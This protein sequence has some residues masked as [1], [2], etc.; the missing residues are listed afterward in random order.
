MNQIQKSTYDA[1]LKGVGLGEPVGNSI[2]IDNTRAPA[3]CSAFAVDD[4][5]AGSCAAL[6]HLAN[7]YGQ[8]IGHPEQ[9]AF[10]DRRHAGNSLNS[11]AWHFQNDWQLD[12]RVVHTDIN[13]FFETKDSRRIIYNGAYPHLR[14]IV[15]DY[16][17]VPN[18]HNRIAKATKQYNALD[19]EHEL[20]QLGACVA[21][22]RSKAEWLEHDQ[23][24]LLS[25]LPVIT[26][27]KIH[28]SEVISI[29]KASR[30][31]EGIKVLDLS[32]VVAG[33]TV[34]RML[35]DHGASVIHL[36][37]PYQDLIYPFDI[38]TSYGKVNSYMDFT[39]AG[40][41]E[42]FEELISEC[43]VFSTGYRFG[44][45]KHLGFDIERVLKLNPNLIH[46]HMNAYGFSG[47]WAEK[48]GFEQ[49]AQSVTGAAAF[50]G[51]GIDSPQLVPAY[52]NDYLTGYLG[53]IGVLAALYKQL[54][55][56]GAWQVDVSLART[57]MFVMEQGH[58]SYDE[59]KDSS[60]GEM[61]DWLV[62]Q[63]GP[64]GTLTRLKPVIDYSHMPCYSSITGT[65]PGTHMAVWNGVADP[66]YPPHYPT[67]R[68][69]HL[70]LIGDMTL[71]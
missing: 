57:C 53:T 21:M 25:A 70:K 19:L 1:I 71:R 59:Q 46:V 35:A 26:L 24:K 38:E 31:L 58:V 39:R 54:S 45:L 63:V 12:I 33:P 13:G 48:R 42:R 65:A 17:G 40:C 49:L 44:G 36:R 8:A 34:A 11:V 43:N 41:N 62:D 27:N 67:K 61:R 64:L 7:I 66:G 29:K 37:H 9:T 28:D 60:L 50:Q 52:M 14:K 6:A 2:S 68:F 23:G 15:L 20:S 4:V 22:V 56:G 5:A 18:D 55:E 30:L 3:I 16:L 51:G 10:I 47:P 32:K 69:E